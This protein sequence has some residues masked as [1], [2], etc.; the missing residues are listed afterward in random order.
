V[1]ESLNAMADIVSNRPRHVQRL[2]SGVIANGSNLRRGK[3]IPGLTSLA[4]S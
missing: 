1:Q 4:T 3:A 2:A